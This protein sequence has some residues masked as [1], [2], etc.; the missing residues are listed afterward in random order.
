VTCKRQSARDHSARKVSLKL[1]GGTL[2][3][4][5]VTA[6]SLQKPFAPNSQDRPEHPRQTL[7]S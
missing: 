4:A 7:L 6:Y 5:A 3:V 1:T 2:E